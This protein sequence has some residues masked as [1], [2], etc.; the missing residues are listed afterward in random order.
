MHSNTIASVVYAGVFLAC[1]GIMQGQGTVSA[2]KNKSEIK[3]VVSA[4][5]SA[6]ACGGE[7]KDQN[8][9]TMVPYT[10]EEDQYDARYAVL[11]YGD[12]ACAGGSGTSGWHLS[13]VKVSMGYFYVVTSCSGNSDDYWRNVHRIVGN[14]KNTITLE[15]CDYGSDDAN[16]CPSVKKRITIKLNDEAESWKE[17]GSKTI[18]RCE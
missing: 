6:V 11:W 18:G 3:R 14:T 4:F 17:I 7:I 9:I 13:L 5:A 8:I 12:W 15:I 10:S 1:L 16:C 2:K